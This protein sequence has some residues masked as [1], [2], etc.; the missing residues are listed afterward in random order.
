MCF[1]DPKMVFATI[2]RNSNIFMTITQKNGK[3]VDS[4]ATTIIN[5]MSFSNDKL[6][7]LFISNNLIL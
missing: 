4:Y 5:L 7:H 3:D 6:K 2:A 1:E